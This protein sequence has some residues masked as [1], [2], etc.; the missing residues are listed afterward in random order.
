V[1][2]RI[3]GSVAAGQ[4]DFGPCHARLLRIWHGACNYQRWEILCADEDGN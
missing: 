4:I 1:V 3:F 2:N